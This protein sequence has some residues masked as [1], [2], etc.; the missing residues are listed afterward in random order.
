MGTPKKT[1][2]TDNESQLWVMA[3]IAFAI[4]YG[5]YMVAP[6]IPTFSNEFSVA[7][8]KLGWVVPGYLIPYGIS[9]LVYGA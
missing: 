6:L 5:N 7:T 2:T 8:H 9:T 4:F 1:G 3:S